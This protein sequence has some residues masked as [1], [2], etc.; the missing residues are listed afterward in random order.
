MDNLRPWF[1]RVLGVIKRWISF[2]IFNPLERAVSSTPSIAL[3]SCTNFCQATHIQCGNLFC[4]VLHLSV[5][6]HIYYYTEGFTPSTRGSS[7]CLPF[8]HYKSKNDC[9]VTRY[10][11]IIPILNIGEDILCFF[12]ESPFAFVRNFIILS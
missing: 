11:L 12:N 8:F 2:K 10:I 1:N 4:K 3:P 5:I 7:L 6:L 9:H